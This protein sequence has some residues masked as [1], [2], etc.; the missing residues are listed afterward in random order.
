ML[1]RPVLA[2]SR[3]GHQALMTMQIAGKEPKALELLNR[4][5]RRKPKRV[6]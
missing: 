2:C 5:V 3:K 4:L 1:Q 6:R